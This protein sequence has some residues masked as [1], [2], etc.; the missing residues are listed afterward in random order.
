MDQE[1]DAKRAELKTKKNL[2]TAFSNGQRV[3]ISLKKEFVGTMLVFLKVL[4]VIRSSLHIPLLPPN[5]LS[6]KNS[7]KE[8]RRSNWLF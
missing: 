4:N 8:I 5:L 7:P 2:A 6:K 1:L 3:L